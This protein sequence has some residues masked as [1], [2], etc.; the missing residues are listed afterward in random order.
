MEV[1]AIAL[2]GLGRAQAQI[3]ASAKRVARP[4]SSESGGIPT[5]VVDLTKEATDIILAASSYKA[6]LA[7]IRTADELEKHV[8]DILA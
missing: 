8:L 4:V 6:N 5:D 1:T 2:E 3:E 7:T